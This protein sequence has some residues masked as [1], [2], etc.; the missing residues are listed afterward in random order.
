MGGGVK[1]QHFCTKA[2]GHCIKNYS[3]IIGPLPSNNAGAKKLLKRALTHK[4]FIKM[5]LKIK[6]GILAVFD[7]DALKSTSHRQVF[8]LKKSFGAN[9][10][11]LILTK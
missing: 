11:E 4:N 7:M 9:L 2:N 6:N 3:E 10:I 8:T 1:K 5:Q